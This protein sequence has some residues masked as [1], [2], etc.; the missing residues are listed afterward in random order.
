MRPTAL[1]K[2]ITVSAFFLC[3]LTLPAQPVAHAKGVAHTGQVDIAYETFGTP[4]TPGKAATA[5]PVIAV[6]GGPGLSHVYMVQNDVWERIARNR[7]VVLYDQRG[8]GASKHLQ[9]GVS[10]SGAP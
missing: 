6:N 2:L 8:T 9:A 5:L 7:M 4:A 1:M 3:S 10:Q